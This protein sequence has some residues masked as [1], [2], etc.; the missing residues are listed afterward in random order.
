MKTKK[1]IQETSKMMLNTYEKFKPLPEFETKF[2]T[3]LFRY[4]YDHSNH[5]KFSFIWDENISVS[6]IMIG[7][8]RGEGYTSKGFQI[9]FSNGLE[10]SPSYIKAVSSLTPEEV[11]E[12]CK[13]I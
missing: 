6:Y 1:Q 7:L 11:V 5:T 4:Y 8:N 2:L 10:E 9:K 13:F 3:N 12:L